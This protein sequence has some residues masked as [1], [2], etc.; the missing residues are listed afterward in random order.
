VRGRTTLPAAVFVAALLAALVLLKLDLR[1]RFALPLAVLA[2]ALGVAM[3]AVVADLRKRVT[4]LEAR[5]HELQQ[6]AEAPS[7]G[8]PSS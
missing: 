2:L 5:V 3:V 4:G 7:R 6:A 8:R 1:P